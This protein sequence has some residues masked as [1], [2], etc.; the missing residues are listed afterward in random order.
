MGAGCRD[1]WGDDAASER[2]GEQPAGRGGTLE[3]RIGGSSLEHGSGLARLGLR[4]AWWSKLPAQIPLGRRIENEI[5]RWGVDTA[6]VLWGMNC[7]RR[8]PEPIQKQV[9]KLKPFA[10]DR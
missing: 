1:I 8:V 2:A 6:Q 3:V 9:P 7:L 4:V 10:R 5:R